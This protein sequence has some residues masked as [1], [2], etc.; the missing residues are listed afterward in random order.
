MTIRFGSVRYIG[1]AGPLVGAEVWVRA[2]GDELGR[3]TRTWRRVPLRPDWAGRVRWAGRGRPATA[4]RVT[5]EEP[6]TTLPTYPDNP[7]QPTGHRV[8][9]R[10]KAGNRPRGSGRRSATRRA[11]A[12]RGRPPLGAC[13][14][15]RRLG[16]TVSRARRA[17]REGRRRCAMGTARGGGPVGDGDLRRSAGFQAAGH[18]AEADVADGVTQ[19]AGNPRPGKGSAPRR[20]R[21]AQ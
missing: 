12:D 3:G 6:A 1:P 9:S 21:A 16:T 4:C 13:G 2:D 11:L 10:R 20:A 5:G 14:S 17:G 18:A 8:R 7:Q 19:S 15:G